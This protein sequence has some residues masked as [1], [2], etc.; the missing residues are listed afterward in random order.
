MKSILFSMSS[1]GGLSAGKDMEVASSAE[2]PAAVKEVG[3]QSQP[4][5]PVTAVEASSGAPA[6]G[7]KETE[8]AAAEA[9]TGAPAGGQ[10]E[11]GVANNVANPLSKNQQKKQIRRER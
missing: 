1:E 3:E 9:P 2:A 7:Q 4:A 5:T 6:G 10:K 8:V 11:K